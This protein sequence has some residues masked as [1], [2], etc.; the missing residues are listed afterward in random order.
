[1]PTVPV[2]LAAPD[3]DVPLDLAAVFRE[4]YDRCRYDKGIAYAAGPPIA[5]R[6][7]DEAWVRQVIGSRTGGR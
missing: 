5:L 7:D 2:P 4:T 1:M 3:P 6:P